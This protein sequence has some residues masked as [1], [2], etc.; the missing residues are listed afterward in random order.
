MEIERNM[1][2]NTG[3]RETGLRTLVVIQVN[4]EILVLFVTVSY[5]NLS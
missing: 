5:P 1:A 4:N 2:A 3:S